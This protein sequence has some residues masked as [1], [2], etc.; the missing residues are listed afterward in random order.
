MASPAPPSLGFG[1]SSPTHALAGGMPDRRSNGPDGF[2]R[3]IGLSLLVHVVLIAGVAQVLPNAAL[4]YAPPRDWVAALD[5][6]LPP[7]DAVDPLGKQLLV[8]GLVA[9]ISHDGR[10]AVAEAELLRVVC[11]SLHCPLPPMLE[12]AGGR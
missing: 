2:K 1:A 8:E 11:S 6:A 4:A 7:L 5:R 9:A 12:S 3:M 10:V